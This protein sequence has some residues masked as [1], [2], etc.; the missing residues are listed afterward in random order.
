LGCSSCNFEGEVGKSIESLLGKEILSL[1]HG[2]K[3][4]FTWVGGEDSKSLVSGKGRPFFASI[5]EPRKRSLPKRSR[6]ALPEGLRI[7]ISKILAARPRDSQPFKTTALLNVIPKAPNLPASLEA[8]KFILRRA[9]GV[10]SNIKSH[11]VI[12]RVYSI[13][14]DSVTPSKLSLRVVFEGGLSLKNFVSGGEGLTYP[15]L[16]DILGFKVAI[17]EAEPFDVLDVKLMASLA[18]R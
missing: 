6:I 2:S 9:T 11:P 15:S 7:H 13:R 8:G 4:K 1:F 14:V 5:S 16:S 3:V 17:D 18:V 10:S 12:R